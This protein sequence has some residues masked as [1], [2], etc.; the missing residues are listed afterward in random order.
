MQFI[1]NTVLHNNNLERTITMEIAF[2]VIA[3]PL[4]FHCNDSTYNLIARRIEVSSLNYKNIRKPLNMY[5]I[6]VTY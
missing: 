1:Y 4:W 2:R 3:L 6:K 5:F